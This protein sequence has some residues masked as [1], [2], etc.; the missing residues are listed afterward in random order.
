MYQLNFLQDL[1][2][3]DPDLA[4]WLIYEQLEMLRSAGKISDEAWELIHAF[5][6]E[7]ELVVESMRSRPPS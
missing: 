6:R 4:C 7:H 2:T 1:A 3:A 5:M